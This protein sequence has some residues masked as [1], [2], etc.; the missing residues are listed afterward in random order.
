MKKTIL[1]ILTCLFT[2]LYF[3]VNAQNQTQSLSSGHR[4]NSALDDPTNFFSQ[5]GASSVAYG[6]ATANI[7]MPLEIE[8][9]ADLSFGAFAAGPTPGTVSI[10]TSGARS[11]NGGL[12][13]MSVNDLS[14]LAATFMVF[15][16]PSASFALTLPSSVNIS[17]GSSQMSIDNFVTDLGSWPMLDPSGSALM[18]VGATI[19]VNA[20]QEPGTY[21]GSFDVTVA[22]N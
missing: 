3:G 19:N 17:N 7:V 4:V 10:S 14:P 20:D 5:G 6:S 13:M 8:K 9:F 2:M 12:T 22:Y 11:F 15:G 1:V 18:N 16:Y 21:V